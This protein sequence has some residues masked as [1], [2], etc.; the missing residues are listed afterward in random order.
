MEVPD[1][2]KEDFA[3]KRITCSMYL[4]TIHGLV[5]IFQPSVKYENLSSN[6]ERDIFQRVQLGM[7]LSAAGA[8]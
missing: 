8:W 5:L 4:S 6:L 2:W 7:P 1:Y 3:G